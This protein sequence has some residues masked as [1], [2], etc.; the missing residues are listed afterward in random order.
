MENNVIPLHPRPTPA[1]YIANVLAEN[2]CSQ[3]A[4]CKLVGIDRP[5][6]NR[7]LKGQ[8]FGE[9]YRRL[10]AEGLERLDGKPWREH[11][12]RLKG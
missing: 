7:I 1:A 4:F 9:T 2:C 10:I 5:Y 12:R 8:S 3:R 6:F 11:A